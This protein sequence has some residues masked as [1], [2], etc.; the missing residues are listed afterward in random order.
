[1]HVLLKIWRV[2]NMKVYRGPHFQVVLWRFYVALFG[3]AA[4]FAVINVLIPLHVKYIV[5]ILSGGADAPKRDIFVVVGPAI[6]FFSSFSQFLVLGSE[7]QFKRFIFIQILKRL[8]KAVLFP[9]ALLQVQ[10]PRRPIREK[11][12]KKGK[13]GHHVHQIP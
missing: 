12:K 10:C 6:F 13:K 8:I 5:G 3:K 4:L 7:R 2:R 9:K 11:R 1:M